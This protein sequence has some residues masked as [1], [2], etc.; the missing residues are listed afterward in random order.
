MKR[1]SFVMMTLASAL[2]ATDLSA[3]P[4]PGEPGWT[5][6]TSPK[7]VIAAR[8]GLMTEMERLMQPIDSFTIGQPADLLDLSSAA[9]TVSRILLVLPHLFPPTTN[10]Y[11]PAA[12][13]PATI[14]LPAIWQNF[15]AFA[16]FADAASK[17][18]ATMAS[19]TEAEDL[20]AAGL[21]LRAACDAC[22]TPFLRAYVPATA[23]AA[24]TDFNFDSVFDKK[25]DAAAR[26]AR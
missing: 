13:E 16:A 10:L 8:Q 12:E 25:P 15:P 23:G 3:D 11:D 17:S 21:R 19:K 2:L 20:R 6:I 24:D 1:T 14:A 5:G 4:K 26:P 9:E 18:A 7:D 22:H